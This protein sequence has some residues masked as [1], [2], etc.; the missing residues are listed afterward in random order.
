M[1][2]GLDSLAEVDRWQPGTFRR[3]AM[4]QYQGVLLLGPPGSGKS[5][6]GDRIEAAGL[7]SRRFCHFDFGANLRRIAGNEPA[8]A[9][10]SPEE[11]RFLRDVLQSGALLEDSH[12]SLAERILTQFLESQCRDDQREVVLNGLPR[13]AGQAEMVGRIVRVHTV[14]SLQCSEQVVLARIAG[15]VG[16]DR[17]DRS[18]DNRSDV[19]RKLAVFAK[20]T[21]LL[22]EYYRRAGS[23][24]VT[25]PVTAGMTPEAAWA[26]LQSRVMASH[27]W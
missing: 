27:G 18:D 6:L 26:G 19:R 4:T 14:V 10:F 1:A 3:K 9:A 13:H 20:R 24:V 15:N 7:G 2:D 12:F 16:G 23:A 17:T 25:L 5:L 8:I 22:V 21:G 11:R